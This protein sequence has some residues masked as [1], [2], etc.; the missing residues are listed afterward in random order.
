MRHQ[1]PGSGL[2]GLQPVYSELVLAKDL[3]CSHFEV[4]EHAQQGKIRGQVP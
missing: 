4:K 2:S 3:N 1:G